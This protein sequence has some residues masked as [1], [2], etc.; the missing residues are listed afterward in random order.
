MKKYIT[1]KQ[2]ADEEFEKHPVYRIY[3]N[4]SKEQIGI[5]SY[6]RPWKEYVFSSRPECVFNNSCLVDVLDFINTQIP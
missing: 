3:N 4:K 5:I 6:Y 2:I 1:I